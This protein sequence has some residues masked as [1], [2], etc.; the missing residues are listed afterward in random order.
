MKLRVALLVSICACGGSEKPAQ[1]PAKTEAA[2]PL[3]TVAPTETEQP[4]A[5]PPPPVVY[6]RPDFKTLVSFTEIRKH[7]ASAR[8]DA[9]LRGTPAYRAFPSIDPVRDL[10]WMVWHGND[11]IVRY[12]LTDEVVE[13]EIARVGHRYDPHVA[14]VR[15][16]EGWVNSTH[17]AA[18]RGAESHLV[19]IAPVEHAQA[20]AVDL[21][22]SHPGGAPSFHTNE[23]AHMRV[24]SPAGA[25]AGFPDDIREV[26]IWIDS[27]AADGG[28]DIYGEGDCPTASAAQADAAKI[29]AAIRQKNTFAVRLVTNG[30]FNNVEITSAANRVRMHINAT[31]AQIEAMMSLAAAHYGMPRP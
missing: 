24:R 21:A 22:D 15:G 25:L 19:V 9:V 30:L 5:P 23:A 13:K 3:P 6:E 4:P 18:L 2:L 31:S 16:W 1:A 20:A 26:E 10:D 29:A 7:P 17:M 27:R 14:G 11:L 28:A 12:S 8:L